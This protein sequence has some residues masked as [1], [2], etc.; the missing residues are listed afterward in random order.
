MVEGPIY[1]L[2]ETSAHF[3]SLKLFIPLECF[4]HIYFFLENDKNT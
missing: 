3:E 2:I 4:D 1:G